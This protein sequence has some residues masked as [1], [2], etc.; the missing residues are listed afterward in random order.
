MINKRIEN[1]MKAMKKAK[2]YE[3][4]SIWNNKLQQLFE[5]KARR[6][7]ERLEDQARVVH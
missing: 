7:Y 1:V 3:M 6:A 2:D 5:I 4:K